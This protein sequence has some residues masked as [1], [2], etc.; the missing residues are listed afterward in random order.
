MQYHITYCIFILHITFQTEY[1]YPHASIKSSIDTSNVTI[2]QVE[3]T[4]A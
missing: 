3:A 1:C 2:K 4:C